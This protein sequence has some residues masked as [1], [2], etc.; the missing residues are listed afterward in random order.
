MIFYYYVY[1]LNLFQCYQQ[2]LHSNFKAIKEGCTGKFLLIHPNF[3]QFKSVTVV[4]YATSKSRKFLES[5]SNFAGS[6]KAK[7]SGLIFSLSLNNF[8]SI[9]YMLSSNGIQSKTLEY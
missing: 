2:F 6:M 5:T 3:N 8:F 4:A 7:S 1:L 9:S